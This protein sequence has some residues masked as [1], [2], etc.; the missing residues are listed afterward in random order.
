M[1]KVYI[2][3]YGHILAEDRDA[4]S[5]SKSFMLKPCP[6]CK[7]E[8]VGFHPHSLD[9]CVQCFNCCA[10]GPKYDY[11]IDNDWLTPIE[12]I[13]FWNRKINAI[14]TGR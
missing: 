7:S 8:D 9:T 6:F 10:Q 12:A 5:D 2:N 4:L 1:T 13:K 11:R 3:K 14:G